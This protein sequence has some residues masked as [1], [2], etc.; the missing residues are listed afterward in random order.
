MPVAGEVKCHYDV[1]NNVFTA[2]WKIPDYRSASMQL[3]SP[4]FGSRS[5][6]LTIPSSLSDY[7]YSWHLAIHPHGSRRAY[8]GFVSLYL[9]N[10]NDLSGQ[11]EDPLPKPH[12]K[13]TMKMIRMYENMASVY[14]QS[15]ASKVYHANTGGFGFHHFISRHYLLDEESCFIAADDSLSVTLVIKHLQDIDDR[16]PD[17]TSLLVMHKNMHEYYEQ[18]VSCPESCFTDV[19]F[20]I[21]GKSLRAHKFI[22]AARSPVFAAMFQSGMQESQSSV[23]VIEDVEAEVMQ[24]VIRYIY[25]GDI[26]EEHEDNALFAIKLFAAADKYHLKFLRTLCESFIAANLSP[27]IVSA[28][29]IA[30]HLHD[31]QLIKRECF[32]LISRLEEDVKHLEDWAEVHRI[33]G[34]IDEMIM[35][36]QK[37]KIITPCL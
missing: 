19:T 31:S 33:P 16:R 2:V 15:H 8:N 7:R 22:L 20:Q 1:V 6:P 12:V 35:Y 34:L 18:V 28:A 14:K 25:C 32:K 29:M 21:D 4:S 10:D 37:M 13:I 27:D 36:W 30:G 5:P 23:I 24:A 11:D 17:Q 3:M 26:E 9:Y